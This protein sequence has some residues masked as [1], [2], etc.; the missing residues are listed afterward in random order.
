RRVAS[1]VDVVGEVTKG[2][3][4]DDALALVIRD[5]LGR[6]VFEEMEQADT[7]ADGAHVTRFGGHDFIAG[8][9]AMR[10]VLAQV[11]QAADSAV[12]VLL[13]GETGTGKEI[14]ARALHHRSARARARF[15]VQ[16]C[17]AVVETLLES[18]LFGHVRGAFTGADRDRSGLFLEADGGTVFL[19]EIG[20][21]P[22]SVQA[23]LLRVLQHGEVK[24]VGADR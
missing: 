3:A 17:G 19:D 10:S 20:E 1:R 5:A 7:V 14:L 12:P 24:P 23:R 6:A 21:A 22:P 9:T 8:T 4:T 11:E 2:A 13:E 16:N 15:V 18:E